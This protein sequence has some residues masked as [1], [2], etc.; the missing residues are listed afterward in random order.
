MKTKN[1][2]QLNERDIKALLTPR[3]RPVPPA[4]LAARIK[5]QIPADLPVVP[6]LDGVTGARRLLR[7]RTWLMA[8]SVV[9]AVGGGLLAVRLMNQMVDPDAPQMRAATVDATV[10]EQESDDAFRSAPAPIAG[11]KQRRLSPSGNR[12]DGTETPA[13]TMP[14]ASKAQAPSEDPAGRQDVTI[15]KHLADELG[16]AGGTPAPQDLDGTFAQELRSVEKADGRLNEARVRLSDSRRGELEEQASSEL[17]RRLDAPPPAAPRPEPTPTPETELPEVEVADGEASV[18][19]VR[20]SS[21]AGTAGGT[22]T[23]TA[24]TAPAA[25]AARRRIVPPP[26]QRKVPP[27]EQAQVER[28]A[29]AHSNAHVDPNYGNA[30]ISRMR[31]EARELEAELKALEDPRPPA[32][33]PPSTGGTAEPNDAPYGDVFFESA[34]TNPFVDTEDDALSTFGLDVDTGSYTVARRYLRDGHLPPPEAVR[35]EEFINYFDYGDAPPQRKEFAIHAEGA[36]SIYAGGERYYLLRFN[37][38]GRQLARADRRPALLTFVVDVSGSMRRENRLGLVKQALALLI[39]QL[40]ADDRLALVVYGSRGQ[41]VLQ[42]TGDHGAIRRAVDQLRTGGSTNAG[43]GL[44]LA[45]ELAAR[46]R[47]RGEINRVI[48]CSDGVAN[49]G[50]T[51]ADSILDRIRRDAN[52]GIELTTVGFGMGNYNDVLMEH[53]ADTGN[54]RYAYVDT[55]DEARRIFV[56]NLTGTLQTLAAE[57]RVQVEL[58]P[59]VVSR[60]RLLGYENRDIADQRFRDDTVDA[61]EIGVGH[62]VT[63]LYE[64]KLHGKLNDRDRVGT[65]RLRY[66]SIESGEMVELE[67]TVTGAD[68]AHRWEAASPA[69]RLTSL[70]AEYAEI[71]KRSYWAREGDLDDVFRRAQRLSANFGGDREVADFVSLVGRAAEYQERQRR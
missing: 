60:Y 7:S 40:R 1:D 26:R 41:V 61:G 8:A 2:R 20:A 10:A 23:A 57:A 68:F 58:D 21:G 14:P 28:Y 38:S 18:I 71:L 49:V 30:Q 37:L 6:S 27:T 4:D 45:Y 25:P 11:E 42:P 54:G 24:E 9:V 12:A 69:L 59:D 22:I 17:G 15:D 67:R 52:Q 50:V 29:D 53:L 51:S 33:A 44:E 46:Y 13:G 16:A 62:K 56:E 65:V 39:D 66:G 55:I 31:K 63:A 36:P 70:V 64:I 34:G 3:E 48:L 47:R 43:E 32:A 35:V 19:E 5:R